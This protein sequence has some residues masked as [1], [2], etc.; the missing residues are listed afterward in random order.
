MVAEQV[1][2]V[3]RRQCFPSSSGDYGVVSTEI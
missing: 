2:V 1:F 3:T